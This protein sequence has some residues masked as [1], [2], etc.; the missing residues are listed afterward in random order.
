MS[1]YKE[2]KEVI[3]IIRLEN[4]S[5]RDIAPMIWPSFFDI[6][7]YV[8]AWDIFTQQTIKQMPATRI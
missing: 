1:M 5:V 4:A 7:I 6:F 8:S 3:S 2:Y